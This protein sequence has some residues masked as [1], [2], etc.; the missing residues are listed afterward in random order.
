MTK[1]VT[2]SGALRSIDCRLDPVKPIRGGHVERFS[3]IATL[4]SA[5]TASA[6]AFEKSTLS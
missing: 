1:S 3:I 6:S 4:A 5:Q 2:A